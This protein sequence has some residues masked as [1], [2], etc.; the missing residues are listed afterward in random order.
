VGLCDPAPY[1]AGIE[2]ARH[3]GIPFYRSADEMV[4]SE[5]PDWLFNLSHRSFVHRHLTGRSL[6]DVLV[7]DESTA[8]IGRRVLA[9]LRTELPD[10]P[11]FSETP[12]RRLALKLLQ[13]IIRG[14]KAALDP[15]VN[16][17]LR[18]PLTG[19][20]ARNVLEDLIERWQRNCV[21]PEERL[22]VMVLDIDN[23][24]AVNDVFGHTAGDRVLTRLGEELANLVRHHDLVARLGG[25]EFGIA[26]VNVE[27]APIAVLADRVRT[28]I[29]QRIARPGG[30]PLT[31]SIGCAV[32]RCRTGEEQEN[33]QSNGLLQAADEAMYLAKAAGG[34]QVQLTPNDTGS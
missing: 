8:E 15:V 12:P 11:G 21:S 6:E 7:V 28:T 14:G 18:D 9:T 26:M 23:F 5:R 32:A 3:K 10:G 30:E 27:N 31:V 2:L 13:E 1:V 34:D 4:R 22:G 16:D 20:Y 33:P 19:L 29:R 25:E 17:A 24:K